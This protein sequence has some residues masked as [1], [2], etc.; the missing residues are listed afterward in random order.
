MPWLKPLTDARQVFDPK[1]VPEDTNP[2]DRLRSDYP[3]LRVRT[4]EMRGHALRTVCDVAEDERPDLIV[5]GH[6][7]LRAG[8]AS[9]RF[10][11]WL[12]RPA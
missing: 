11:P 8:T 2:T 12:P 6:G 10:A 9:C 5:V 7:R 1:G 3:G 4:S